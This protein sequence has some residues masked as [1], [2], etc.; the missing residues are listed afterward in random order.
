MR[1]T[2]PR[3]LHHAARYISE[4]I[5]AAAA[6]FAPARGG[7]VTIIA[8]VGAVPLLLAVGAAIDYS[9][10]SETSS[11][12]QQALDSAALGTLR[13]AETATAD[14]TRNAALSMFQ[15]GFKTTNFKDIVFTSEYDKATKSLTLTARGS[16]PSSFMQLAGIS[17]TSV[18]AIAKASM[19]GGVRLP[20]CVMVT[21]P[22]SGH[23]LL[24]KDNAT[25]NFHN[26]MVQVNTLNWDAVE[27]RDTSYIHSTN[28]QN[29]FVGDI[30]YGD[31]LPPKSP[32]C[33]FFQDPFASLSSPIKGC[34]FTNVVVVTPGTKLA[35]GTYCNGLT[36][37]ATTTFQPGL[38]LIRGDLTIAGTGVN[39]TADEV[40][41]VLSG[42]NPSF[43]L[44]TNGKVILNAN[45][46]LAAGDFAGFAVYVDATN[47][48]TAKKGKGGKAFIGKADMQASGIFYFAG[49][50]FAIE[51]G[52]KVN[53]NPGSIVADFILPVSA[54]LQLY[55]SMN[56][57]T[58]AEIQMRKTSETGVPVLVR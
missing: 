55:G 23:T 14:N 56:T 31:V 8:A 37:K 47:P 18:G 20:V 42:P 4:K 11:N 39:I 36:V 16:L 46:T 12:L 49:Q 41:F 38:Y 44:D 19:G 33:T 32:T 40:T 2:G 15:A 6:A 58:S 28:G 43:S 29:C 50:T 21:H 17:A 30:H 45:R 27:A 10:I 9:R 1:L 51:D 34:D 57:A 24:V 22:D 35:P 54:S 53:I 48:V 5:C 7:N 13:T 52:A 26:C 3:I 25:I